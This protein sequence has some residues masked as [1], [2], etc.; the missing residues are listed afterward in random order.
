[1]HE[2]V[3]LMRDIKSSSKILISFCHSLPSVSDG[4][5]KRRIS[6]KIKDRSNGRDIKSHL[7]KYVLENDRQDVSEKYFKIN[8]NAL[9]GNNKQRKVAEALLFINL[10]L[11]FLRIL[12][13]FIYLT[14]YVNMNKQVLH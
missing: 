4:K 5:A 2:T 14:F 1:M 7:L 8:G 11:M 9:R 13:D 12:T 10:I 3:N 6:E